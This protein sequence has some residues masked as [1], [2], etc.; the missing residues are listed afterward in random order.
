MRSERN[1][2]I[3]LHP[4][5]L[6]GPDGIGD[7]GPEAYQWIDFLVHSG[8][9][10]W[11][12][13]P[14]GPT[15]FG[16]SPYQCFSAFAGNPYLISAI[17][18]VDDGLLSEKD[19]EDR[20]IF[21]PHQVDYGAVIEW[22]VTLLKRAYVHFCKSRRSQRKAAYADFQE[23]N[24]YWL[25]DFSLFMAIKEFF[26]G[27]PWLDWPAGFK[28]KDEKKIKEFH[29][30]NIDSIERVKFFQF[31]FFEQWTRLKTYANE[32]RVKIIGDIPIFVAMDSADTWSHPE[33]FQLKRNGQ[34]AAVAGVPPDYFSSTGQ[35]WG[36]PLYRWS[37]HKSSRFEWWIA[38]VKNALHLYDMIR[39]DHFRGFSAYWSVPA[40]EKTAVRGKWLPGPGRSLFKAIKETLG[41]LPILAEDLGEITPDVIRLRDGLALPGMKIL[42]FAFA[43]DA[44]N[45]FLPHNYLEN[46]VAY[47]GTHDNDTS[48]GWYAKASEKEKDFCRRYLARSGDNIAW[49]LIR[50]GWSSV[51]KM[52]LAP[53][54]DFLNLGSE[55][56]M[57]FP[58][59][60]DGNWQWRMPYD[61]ISE[62]LVSQISE[63]NAL[64]RRGCSN[65]NQSQN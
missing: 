47:T 38:R 16:D 34:P 20:P 5:S 65:L 22:K 54:Q 62:A 45:P 13:L 57:N 24:A 31:T 53:M 1:A 19:L 42:Q 46:C 37:A 58:S 59:R 32:K 3:I 4:T 9:D 51:A 10:L 33:L 63:F 43:D 44:S 14:L 56:R 49:D 48:L 28:L 6:P 15:G 40:G 35:L 50:A 29:D 55:S 12:V 52:A 30:A 11:Q 7:L 64:Y 17:A 21:Q 36:N 18:L 26:G 61:A 25:N 27:K 8:C 2:G 23:K 60:A 41:S 39:L